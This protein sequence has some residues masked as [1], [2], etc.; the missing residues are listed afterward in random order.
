MD[1]TVVHKDRFRHKGSIRDLSMKGC[2][3]HSMIT[4]FTGMQV[5]ILLHLPG[6]ANPITIENAAIRWVGS[7][8]IGVEFL[9]VAKP[10]QDRLNRVIQQLEN[11]PPAVIE[12]PQTRSFS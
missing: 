10:D 4:P 1:S 7:A 6:E 2:R 3:V 11:K 8:G 5:S 9:I 12:I